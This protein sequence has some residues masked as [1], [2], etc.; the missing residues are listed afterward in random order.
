MRTSLTPMESAALQ[1]AATEMTRDNEQPKK[2]QKTRLQS[3]SIHSS[4]MA[5]IFSAAEESDVKGERRGSMLYDDTEWN[6]NDDACPI[7][8]NVYFY[9]LDSRNESILWQIRPQYVVMYHPDV[10][11]LRQVEVFQVEHGI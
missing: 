6:A 4:S 8:R 7:L 2:K 10:A 1:T 9:A 11:F 3:I 5:R